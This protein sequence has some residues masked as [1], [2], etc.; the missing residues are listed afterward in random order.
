[1]SRY[2][3]LSCSF[4]KTLSNTKRL[5]FDPFCH[6]IILAFL[7]MSETP[8]QAPIYLYSKRAIQVVQLVHAFHDEP[9]FITGLRFTSNVDFGPKGYIHILICTFSDYASTGGVMNWRGT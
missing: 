3:N 9:H 2:N 6:F 5:Q 1:M 4:Q 8:G 7:Y